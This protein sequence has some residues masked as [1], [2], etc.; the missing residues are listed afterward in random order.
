MARVQSGQAA[1]WP[2]VSDRCVRSGSGVKRDFAYTLA[3]TFPP[4]LVALRAQSRLGLEGG[5]V[6]SAGH[7]WI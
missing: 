6:P 4:A 1:A 3:G 5:Y 2:L 7:P